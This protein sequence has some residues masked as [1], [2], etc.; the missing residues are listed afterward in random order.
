MKHLMRALI[1]IA[2][3]LPLAFSTSAVGQ[4]YPS[5]PVRIVVPYTPGS[6]TDN[7][8]RIVAEELRLSMGAAFIVENKAGAG[9]LI[10]TEQVARAAPDGYTLT[11]SSSA[12]HSSARF[13]FKRMPVDEMKDF[14]HIA[15]LV[16]VPFVLVVNPTTP[17]NDV[18][19]FV[20]YVRSNQSKVAHGY[21]SATSQIMAATF[22]NLAGLK[23][24]GVPYKSQPPTVIDLIS[25]QVQYSFVDFAN[26]MP[27]AKAGKLRALAVT[28]SKRLSQAPDLPTMAESGFPGYGLVAWQ[29][30]SAPAGTP[31]EIVQ[32]INKEV[33][34]A[35]TKPDVVAKLASMGYDIVPATVEEFEQFVAQQIDVWGKRVKD[36]GI[37][38][39]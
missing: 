32:R 37:E 5:K 7:I 14:A 8:A 35:L 24:V 1:L 25:N 6:G 28:T 33:N 23:T 34:K 29:G 15:R 18:K 26:S 22:E 20:E 16:Q 12:T 30:L 17:A 13:L 10:G 4:P 19:Q 3:S 11:I 39:Q 21:G 2:G 38:P 31:S 27:H 9:G 36:A